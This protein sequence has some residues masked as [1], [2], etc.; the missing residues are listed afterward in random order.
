MSGHYFLSVGTGQTTFEENIMRKIWVTMGL[1]SALFVFTLVSCGFEIPT[2]VTVKGN[3]GLYVPLGSPFAGEDATASVG[4]FLSAKGIGDMLNSDAVEVGVFDYKAGTYGASDPDD[5]DPQTYL[6]KY[7]IADM[8]LDLDKSIGDIAITQAEVSVTVPN[9]TQPPYSMLGT[10]DENNPLY[11]TTGTPPVAQTETPVVTITFDENTTKWITEITSEAGA[12][13]LKFTGN[14]VGDIQVAIPEWGIGAADTNGN[15]T[16]WSTGVSSSG[17]TEFFN[18]TDC[19][20]D[21]KHDIKVYIAIISTDISNST[22]APE[23]EFAW[24]NALINVQTE[25]GSTIF[26]GLKGEF[27]LDLSSLKD[28]LGTL[29][30]KKVDAYVYINNL[31]SA[32]DTNE[33]KLKLT[34]TP[35]TGSETAITTG[36]NGYVEIDNAVVTNEDLENTEAPWNPD[37]KNA[38][39]DDALDF[40][41]LFSAGK[42]TLGY[43]L[44][45][46]SVTITKA[47]MDNKNDDQTKIT[48]DIL[49][50]LPLEF[51]VNEDASDKFDSFKDY[52][53]DK[54]EKPYQYGFSKLHLAALGDNTG[55][56][57]L[58]GRTGD[59]DD[60]F[61]DIDYLKIWVLA[62]GF[63][64]DIINGLVLGVFNEPKVGPVTKDILDLEL[65]RPQTGNPTPKNQYIILE[66]GYPFSPKFEILIPRPGL[67]EPGTI[68]VPHQDTG[69][70]KL[71]F[72]IAVEAQIA[73]D[74]KIDL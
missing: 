23:M 71:D 68:K 53:N 20:W 6:I 52:T 41:S 33:H 64:N 30:F 2:S 62:S 10:I 48:V 27:P 65:L 39:L 60:M 3:P 69:N 28:T 8:N 12:L 11:L 17:E 22:I 54:E 9:L 57:D 56:G 16:S 45:M 50:K 72:K 24:L 47:E 66:P 32:G 13:G 26:D 25:D 35:T 7:H 40:T 15:I 44:T 34:Y 14:V 31:P 18:E 5:N 55:G 51:E 38:S 59:G 21:P 63:E 49:I 58:L 1:L 67:N 43:E 37:D 36:T 73:L 70:P 4:A 19:T 29:S 61:G 42:A 74:Y 46:E